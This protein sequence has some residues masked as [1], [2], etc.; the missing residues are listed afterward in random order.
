MHRRPV[1]GIAL[2]I[3]L[4]ACAGPST[5]TSSLVGTWVPQTAEFDGDVM[6][7]TSFQGAVLQLAADTYAFGNDRGTYVVV[8]IELPSSMNIRGIEGPNAD[9]TIFAIYRRDGDVLTIC[10]Q[11]G[12]GA[13]PSAFTTTKG[14]KLLLV[15]YKRAA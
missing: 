6:P 2:A 12:P 15:R 9:R 3:A 8:S 5:S 10:Y 11:L 14:S 1:L 13:R 4:T 7:I